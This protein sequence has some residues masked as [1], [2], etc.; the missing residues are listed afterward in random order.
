MVFM[1]PRHGKSEIVSRLF[2]AYFLRRNPQKFVGLS[3]YAAD[4][5]YT[6]S[7]NARENYRGSGGTF[8]GRATAVKQ[9]ETG[10]GGGMWAAGVGGPITGKGFDVGIIDDPLKNA[11]EAD[12]ATIREKQRDWYRS[13]FY[14]R[15]EPDAAI[16]VIQ[17]RWHDDDLS[18]WLLDS[19]TDSDD[20][21]ERWHIVSMQAIKEGERE[22]PPTCTVEPDTR[23]QGEALCAERYS[24]R[25]LDRIK[26]RIGGYYWSA[27]Y[28]QTPRQREGNTFKRHWF[29][30]VDEVPARAARV[31]WWDYASTA[32]RSG[33]QTV[34]VLMA[35]FEGVFY[36][37]DVVCGRWESA[38]RDKIIKRTSEADYAL[39]SAFGVRYQTW[40]EQEPGSSGLDTARAFVAMLQGIPAH[41]ET[42]TGSKE[43]RADPLVA[44]AGAGNVRIKR[45]AWNAHYLDELT[46]FPNASNDD[47]VDASSGAY[48]KLVAVA[49]MRRARSRAY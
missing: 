25:R 44:Q 45:A 35:Y 15:A 3:S 21:P 49:S 40:R 16:I 6:L 20:E 33:D 41:F 11:E 48:N 31:R 27:L 47:Q 7:R 4:L 43:L 37:E 29:D 14:T 12:S 22:F 46:G 8:D 30:F 39:Y 26:A 2:T 28:Q 17:T 23:D 19:E 10:E 32:S 38:E 9:W 42:S 18:G 5:A 24:V 1:P 34:G 13:T 36:I